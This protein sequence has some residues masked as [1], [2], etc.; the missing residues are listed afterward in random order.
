V[1]GYCLASLRKKYMKMQRTH[2]F[3]FS[4]DSQETYFE[5]KCSIK[6]LNLVKEDEHFLKCHTD[7]PN[8]LIDIE[9]RQYASRGLTNVN[10]NMFKFFVSLTERILSILVYDNLMKYGKNIYNGCLESIIQ[11]KSLY[12]QFTSVIV[13]SYSNEYVEE[14]GENSNVTSVIEKL[15]W[16][17]S[18]M[19]Q[20]YNELVKKYLMVFLAQFRKDIKSDYRVE[21]TMAH[22]KQIKVTKQIKSKEKISLENEIAP[23]LKKHVT[24][25]K[26][27]STKRKYDDTQVKIMEEPIAGPSSRPDIMESTPLKP[28]VLTQ[29]NDVEENS[30]DLCQ[31][32]YVEKCDEWIQCDSCDSWF[33]RKCAGL[34]NAKQWKKHSQSGVTWFCRS[35]E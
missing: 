13:K 11:D 24:R 15:V 4:D 33:H 16:F 31:A 29:E 12:E 20:I 35:C 26:N 14:F 6:I 1:A 7:E 2:V 34:K 32:C 9:R 27:T 5:S 18:K 3:S 23:T 17:S 30:S 21:K 10:D 25:S 8:S 22:R 19:F 28:I